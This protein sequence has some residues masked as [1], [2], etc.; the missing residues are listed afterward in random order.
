[1]DSTRKRLLRVALRASAGAGCGVLLLAVR[2]SR[3]AEELPASWSS[4]LVDLPAGDRGA[5]TRACNALANS[6]AESDELTPRQRAAGFEKLRGACAVKLPWTDPELVS[7]TESLVV[8]SRA[9]EA[10][11]PAR[12]CAALRALGISYSYLSRP[13][14]AMRLFEEAVALARR[15]QGRGTVGEDL[16]AA[17]EYQTSGLLDLR[18][19][20]DAMAAA[21]ESLLL[22]Q[23]AVPFRP[24]QVVTAL[25]TRALVEE[26]QLD[27]RSSKATLLEAY[28]LCRT[29]GPG[30]EGEVGRVANNL[31]ETL[32][33]LGEL[34]QAITVLQ[35]A[36]RWRSGGRTNAGAGGSAS[37]RASRG[38]PDRRLASTQANLGQVFFDTGDYPQA[39]EYYRKAVSGHRTWLGEDASRYCDTLTG[40]ALVLEA[41]GQWEEALE[42]LREALTIREAAVQAAPAP[43]RGE[44][45]LTLAR[46]LTHLGALQHRM[47]DPQ[48]KKSLERA[49]SIHEAVLAG[50]ANADHAENLLDLAEYWYDSGEPR[51]ARELVHR[52]LLEL[53]TVGEHGVRELRATEMAARVAEDAASG[54]GAVESARQLVSQLY[55]DRSPWAATV[56]QTRAELRL[57]QRDVAGA[58]SDALVAQE[59]SLPQVRT[60]VQAFP[61]DQALAFA[62]NRRR[63]LDLALRLI[64]EDPGADAERVWRVW[65]A[66]LSSRTLVLN[67]E[68]DRQR[69]LQASADPELARE[70]KRLAAA[71]ERYAHLLVR[72]EVHT[73]VH[74]SQLRSS[75]REAEEAEAVLAGKLRHRLTGGVPQISLEALRHHLPAGAALVAFF[76][77]RRPAGGDA[78]LAFVLN[79]G[80]PPRAISLGSVV[81]VD[82]LIARWREAIL[83][84]ESRAA[85]RTRAGQALRQVIWDPI[86]RCVGAAGTVFVVPDGALHLVPL[87]A[88]ARPDGSYL[89]EQGWAFHTLTA[90]RDLL[91]P[92]APQRPGPWLAVG[93]IDYDA[94]VRQAAF[95]APP[96]EAL[97]GGLGG[98]GAA[99][100]RGTP[101]CQGKG[102]P[103]F[104]ALPGSKEE[105]AE[106]AQ[107]WGRLE[108]TPEG[109]K[110]PLT[111]LTGRAATK[112]AFRRA[113]RGQRLVHLATHGLAVGHGCEVP[114]RAARGIGGLSLG[115]RVDTGE[116]DRLSGLVLAGVNDRAGAGR[117][118]L[119]GIMTEVEILDLDLSSADWV[120]LS[121]C[122]SGLGTIEAGE[123]VVGL[124]RAFRVAGARTVVVSLW[125]I[126]DQAAHEWMRELYSARFE[127][128]LSTIAAVRQA[129]LSSLR[130]SRKRGDDNPAW[131]A[132]FVA[133][134]QWH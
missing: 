121:S 109:A 48:A 21:K 119:E 130:L 103:L 53:A 134:G 124:L 66:A 5:F 108:A 16:A 50:V 73:A 47:G 54:L 31:G 32:Y 51:M 26:G 98:A 61:R 28:E 132:G 70:A 104:G 87:M 80:G 128:R 43:G 92:P 88:L 83:D 2:M 11:E 107:L 120:V 125:S 42:L 94:A 114:R 131:W 29:L 25:V 40:L 113:V 84:A 14:Q 111:V 59:I 39:I 123:G 44:L 7:I 34:P 85:V 78:Y 117:G 3:Q 96:V 20:K 110:S 22:R 101:P 23:N 57:R 129:A 45:Q 81:A 126:D 77:Y 15:Y 69:L 64:G 1:M 19:F 102:L 41:S 49:L 46:S 106:L 133:T 60:V 79:R 30:H 62:T 89:I 56:L 63:S 4:R 55:G 58:L 52:C 97:R 93:G 33:R 127:H 71:R 35:E 91:L 72:N 9:F 17:L 38:Q 82:S 74:L 36:E 68:I 112:E 13:D 115:E 18:R 10:E 122:D 24:E 116:L 86:A 65:R 12:L 76:Q 8:H 6:L 100:A 27:R 67:A 95:V 90:E 37:D 118:E 99:E 75:Q 105:I